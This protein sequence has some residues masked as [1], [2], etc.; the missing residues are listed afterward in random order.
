MAEPRPDPKAFVRFRRARFVAKFPRAYR[1]SPAH[2]WLCE[3]DGEPGL[4]RVGLTHFATRMLGEIVEFDIEA[5][6]GTALGPGK[7]IGWVE[8]MK[9][10]TDLFCVAEGTLLG[11]N[12][13][14]L[15][16]PERV[17]VDPYGGGWLYALRGRP[18]AHC[19]D[20][21]AYLEL[22]GETID[23]MEEQPWKSPEMTAGAPA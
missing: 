16:D 11:A 4:W 18:D 1:Y 20:V 8:G 21:E 3:D 17:C 22:L 23:A 9:A 6:P 13:G 15:G 14:A 12:P 19:L 2:F 5:A 10:V 7:V